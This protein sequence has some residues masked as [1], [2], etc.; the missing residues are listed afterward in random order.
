MYI[1]MRGLM[2]LSFP[3]GDAETRALLAALGDLLEAR[4]P[5]LG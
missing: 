4:G 5:H 1:A 2:A 3:I